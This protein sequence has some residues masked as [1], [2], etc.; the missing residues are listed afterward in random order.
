MFDRSYNNC[1]MLAVVAFS[2]GAAGCG[3][4]RMSDTSRTATEQLLISDAIDRAVSEI[5]FS[6]LRGERVY[7]DTQYLS[8][9]VDRDYL[10]SSLRQHMVASEVRLADRREDANLVL[11]ARAGALGTGRQEV[12]YGV[13]A[14]NLPSVGPFTSAGSIPEIPLAKRT[15]QQGVAK[16][17]VFAYERDSGRRIWQSGMSRVA[18]DSKDL[19]L[20]GAGP[21]QGGTIYRG[22][23]KVYSPRRLLATRAIPTIKDKPRED[24][25]VA[26]SID[27]RRHDRLAELARES[28][29][30]Q[31]K[32]ST[33][34]DEESST[35]SA[36]DAPADSVVAPPETTQATETPPAANAPPPTESEREPVRRTQ[37]RRGGRLLGQDPPTPQGVVPAGGAYL[38]PAA[39]PSPGTV[40]L[41][42]PSQLPAPPV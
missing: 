8:S 12:L 15:V 33:A 14:V 23:G 11:E 10:E 29:E 41:P 37:Q 36:G 22:P 38:P 13:P 9:V 42:S 3:S 35:E 25:A 5:D 40:R 39:P 34:I 32:E 21:F 20:F 30:A 31:S 6:N 24:V 26:T 2:A 1:L 18:A 4:T 19:W 16:L 7:F 17:A 28:Q 27:F